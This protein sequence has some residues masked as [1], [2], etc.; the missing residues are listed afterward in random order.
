MA[1]I[2]PP[3]AKPTGENESTKKTQTKKDQH[4]LTKGN[5][6]KQQDL[7][8]EHLGHHIS[9][10]TN[11]YSWF[12]HYWFDATSWFDANNYIILLSFVFT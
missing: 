10:A 1:Q 12:G 3:K 4:D 8:A 9:S 6:T 7:M 5:K 11:F 2:A